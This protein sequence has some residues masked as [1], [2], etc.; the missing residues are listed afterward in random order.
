MRIA[1]SGSHATG[2]STLIAAFLARR[3]GY[4]HEAEAYE[5][6]ADDIDLTEEAGPTPEGLEA[7]LRHTI[8]TLATFA[9]DDD[10][11]V[12][13]SPVDYLAYAAA[14]RRRWPSADVRAFLDASLPAVRR[15]VHHLDLIVLVPVSDAIGRPG[16]DARFQKRVDRHLRRALIDDD[17]DLLAADAAPRV[18]ELS[19][20]P[21]RRLSEFL[22]LVPDRQ[23]DPGQH[24]RG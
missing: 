10:V 12:E 1:V 21:S 6:L 22:R 5:T 24:Q 4:R 16:E 11:I 23:R 19:P 2:K 9:P 14:N 7:L 8:A 20:V 15:A 18:V 13:R 17:L 3:P